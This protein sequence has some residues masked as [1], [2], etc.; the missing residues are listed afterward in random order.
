MSSY[1]TAFETSVMPSTLDQWVAD[2]GFTWA[3]GDYVLAQT[4]TAGRS[5]ILDR[6]GLCLANGSYPYQPAVDAVHVSIQTVTNA[7]LPSWTEIGSGTIPLEAIP[8]AGHCAW[9]DA[10]ISGAYLTAGT[11]YAIVL[12]T[13]WPGTAKWDGGLTNDYPGGESFGFD[14]TRWNGSNGFDLSFKTYVIPA[15][16]VALPATPPPSPGNPPTWR[17]SVLDELLRR[18]NPSPR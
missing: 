12:S 2:Q 4:F 18:S 6:V 13:S 5:G 16:A 9:V 11:R 3:F 8:P 7:G 1:D 14:G 17:D 15:P 10:G